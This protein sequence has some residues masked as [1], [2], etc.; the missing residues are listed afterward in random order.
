MFYLNEPEHTKLTMS[1]KSIFMWY[2]SASVAVLLVVVFIVNWTSYS[3]HYLERLDKY[4]RA[5]LYLEQAVCRDHSIK[6]ALGDYNNCERSRHIT[7]QSIRWLAISDTALDVARWMGFSGSQLTDTQMFKLWVI[8]GVLL[9]LGLW[10][11]IFR[12]SANREITLAMTPTL[13]TYYES[14]RVATGKKKWM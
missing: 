2:S 8:G 1:L 5:Q 3:Q 13:P 14:Q 11:G 9:F 10:L 4:N 7:Q 6:A 12:M